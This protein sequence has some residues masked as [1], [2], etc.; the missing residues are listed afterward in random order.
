MS[1]SRMNRRQQAQLLRILVKRIIIDTQ[2]TFI[3]VELKAPFAY[4]TGLKPAPDR[5]KSSG[6]KQE[7]SGNILSALSD[8][9]HLEP[10]TPVGQFT[11]MLSFPQRHKLDELPYELVEVNRDGSF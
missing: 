6:N 10:S 2:G 5:Q 7:S 1:D 9:N 8:R 4:L 11:E 3:D